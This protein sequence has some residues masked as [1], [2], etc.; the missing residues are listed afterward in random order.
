MNETVVIETASR[1][2]MVLDKPQNVLMDATV[3]LDKGNYHLI[4][5]LGGAML[6]Y[7]IAV[8]EVPISGVGPDVCWT[9][10][11]LFRS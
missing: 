1:E 2:T 4:N 10:K 5:C 3:V 7:T 6:A 11:Y 9:Y 8:L